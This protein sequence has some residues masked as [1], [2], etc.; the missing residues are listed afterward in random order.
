[1][2]HHPRTVRGHLS[3][4]LPPLSSPTLPLFICIPSPHLCTITPKADDFLDIDSSEVDDF[5]DVDSSE[6]DDF[7]DVDSSEI[8]DFHPPSSLGPEWHQMSNRHIGTGLHE[9]WYPLPS[10]AF[11]YFGLACGAA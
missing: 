5:L 9:L 8:D 3:I 7:L 1:M 10:C 4:S 6:V 2:Q 11:P